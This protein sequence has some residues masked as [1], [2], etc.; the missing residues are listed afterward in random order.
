VGTQQVEDVGGQ[1]AGA[2]VERQRNSSPTAR[3]VADGAGKRQH[4]GQP[5]SPDLL[6]GHVRLDGPV[7]PRSHPK[8]SAPWRPIDHPSGRVLGRAAGQP[9]V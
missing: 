9:P 3:P 5:E 4:P 7:G 6:R 8:S 2:I 1:F